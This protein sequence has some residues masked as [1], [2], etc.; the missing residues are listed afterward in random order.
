M[1]LL[2]L[3]GAVF[4]WGGGIIGS[5]FSNLVSPSALPVIGKELSILPFF[6]HSLY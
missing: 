4:L 6:S 1:Y 2:L 5:D 3:P